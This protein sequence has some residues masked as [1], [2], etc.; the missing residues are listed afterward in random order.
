LFRR[1][2]RSDAMSAQTLPNLNVIDCHHRLL[3]DFFFK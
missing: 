1:Q 2:A 3:S